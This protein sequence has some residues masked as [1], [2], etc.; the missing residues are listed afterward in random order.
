MTRPFCY[1]KD[2]HDLIIIGCGPAGMAAALTAIKLKLKILVVAKDFS[3][4]AKGTEDLE[5]FNPVK[6][7]KAVLKATENSGQ[8][9]ELHLKQE[10]ISLEKNVISFSVETKRGQ[11]YYGKIV[12]IC[13]GESITGHEGNT[14]FDLTAFKDAKNKIKVDSQ[15]ATNVPGLFAAGSVLSEYSGNSF[16]SAGQGARAVFSAEDFLT[17]Q[18]P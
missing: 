6:V 8:F 12:I 16:V 15:M 11:I 2:M 9:L 14:A 18:K 7:R 13:S 3:L 17:R 10:V 1:N 5:L 4:P